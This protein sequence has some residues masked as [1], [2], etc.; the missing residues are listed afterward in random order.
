MALAGRLIVIILAGAGGLTV[1]QAPEFAQQYRQRLGGAVDELREVVAGFDADARR[2]AMSRDEA[3]ASLGSSGTQFVRDH[4]RSVGLT[5][6]RYEK[7]S[8]QQARLLDAPPLMRPIVVLS[9][10]DETILRGAW[11][12]YEPAVPVTNA[13]LVWAG[14][15][16]VLTWGIISLAGQI[17]HMAR[18]RTARREPSWQ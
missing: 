12:D 14:L 18:R 10:P 17:L 3:L 2:S 13:G 8:D 11:S 15:G 4:G 16:F 9:A 6:V 7:L 1:S 5:I